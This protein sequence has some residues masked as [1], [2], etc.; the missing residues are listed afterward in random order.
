MDTCVFHQDAKADIT[1]MSDSI[2]RIDGDILVIQEKLKTHTDCQEEIKEKLSK[3]SDN[4]ISQA[5]DI[6]SLET[7]VATF[8]KRVIEMGKTSD[9]LK[10]G[11][12]ELKANN[13]VGLKIVGAVS[14][15]VAIIEL[16][17]AFS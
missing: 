9:S 14:I 6:V 10:E 11:V 13:S 17:K 16:W 4:A 8:D 5:M 1:L 7:S 3:L 2:K 12:Q 15:L